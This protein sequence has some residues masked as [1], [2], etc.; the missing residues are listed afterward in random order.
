M[1]ACWIYIKGQKTRPY[2]T[3]TINKIIKKE[4]KLQ[5]SYTLRIQMLVKFDNCNSD[6]KKNKRQSMFDLIFE[7]KGTDKRFET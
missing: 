5:L 2:F 1:H 3:Q 4:E 7:K 6:H